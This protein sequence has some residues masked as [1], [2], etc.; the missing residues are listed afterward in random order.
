[1]IYVLVAYYMTERRLPQFRDQ[2][3]ADQ[4]YN[5]KA[6]DSLLNFETVKYFIAESHE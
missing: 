1:M 5:Q 4:R 3:Q 2:S 6:T